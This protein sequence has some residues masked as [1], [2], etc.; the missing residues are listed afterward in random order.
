MTAKNRRLELHQVLRDILGS[1]HCYLSPP[2]GMRLKYPCIIYELAGG[3]T[4][5]AD[6]IPYF[7]D[8]LW[9]VTVIDP[10]PDSEI[11]DRLS[12]L[13]RCRFDRHF[14]SDNLNNYVFSLIF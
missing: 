13:P 3:S 11:P 10:C 7:K 2:T 8:K 9:I 4:L 1:D 14:A 12:E 6:N 5:F